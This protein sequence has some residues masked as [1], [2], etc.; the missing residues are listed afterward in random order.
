MIYKTKFNS[1]YKKKPKVI[2][3]F[4]M[5]QSYDKFSRQNTKFGKMCTLWKVHIYSKNDYHKICHLLGKLFLI[6]SHKI[7][8][9]KILSYEKVERTKKKT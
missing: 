1:W 9:S 6:T 2:S 3:Y 5:I 8:H 4:G 7:F